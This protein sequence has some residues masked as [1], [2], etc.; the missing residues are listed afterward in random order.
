MEL[1]HELVELAV[2]V[3]QSGFFEADS[4]SFHRGT[5]GTRRRRRR[6]RRRWR[7]ASARR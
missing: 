4:A 5:G 6:R 2:F 1:I 3:F 7:R